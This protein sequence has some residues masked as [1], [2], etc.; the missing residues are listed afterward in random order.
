MHV[1]GAVLTGL[2]DVPAYFDMFR[3]NVSW[4]NI[5]TW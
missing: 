5:G 2:A 4:A 1:C 3:E